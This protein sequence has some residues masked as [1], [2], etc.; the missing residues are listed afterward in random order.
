MSK[1]KKDTSKSLIAQNKRATFDYEILEK[2]EAGIELLGS[3]VKS[4][5]LGKGSINESYAA[6]EDNELFLINAHIEEYS[7]ANKRNHPPRRHR[8]LLLHR[9]E[10]NKI[11]G[12]IK[13][14]GMTV[15]PMRMYFDRNGRIKLMIGLAKGKKSHDKR[16][17]IKDRDWKRD[18]A[19]IMKGDKY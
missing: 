4:L 19:R 1:K 16:Q 8:K 15:V 17:T 14:G 10:L 9:R 18:Q 3:E 13:K 2:F 7:F 11:F 12:S 5:R 6:E